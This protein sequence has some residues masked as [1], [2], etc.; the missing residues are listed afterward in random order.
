MIY[1]TT[2]TP[3]LFFLSKLQVVSNKIIQTREH[4]M[5]FFFLT[6]H[7]NVFLVSGKDNEAL[8]ISLYNKC[9]AMLPY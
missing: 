4:K 8:T 5:I 2:E 9:T 1:S 6:I 3:Q 7:L